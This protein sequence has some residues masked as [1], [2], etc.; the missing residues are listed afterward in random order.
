MAGLVAVLAGLVARHQFDARAARSA[1]GAALQALERRRR[2]AGGPSP[3]PSG[4]R[5]CRALRRPRLE[6]REQ[7]ADRLA[8]AGGRLRQQ[9]APARARRGRRASA[10]SRWP[11]RKP[12]CGKRSAREG[13]VARG[14]VRQFAARPRRGRLA[15]RSS[16]SALQV[17]RREGLARRRLH[18]AA[19]VEIDQRD[20][21]LRRARARGTAA[22]RRP[23]P[24]PSAARGGSRA[25]ASS[26]AAMGLDFLE[27][28]R[29]PG[30]S[31]RRGRAPASSRYSP[32]AAPRLR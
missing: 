25:C 12:A 2:P 1:A 29:A 11:A 4:R 14:G 10:S 17:A 3:W 8:D 32:R 5:S 19:D 24:A 31:R 6:Q 15:Q 21:Q 7:R 26:V 13:G 9:A 16:K 23:A 30:R 22:S 28:V 20:A 27:Q 18:L